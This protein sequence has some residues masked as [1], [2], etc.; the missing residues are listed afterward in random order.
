M[1]YNVRHICMFLLVDCKEA[2]HVECKDRL[3]QFCIP[4]GTTPSKGTQGNIISDFAPSN[5]P[6]VPSIILQCVNQVF[7]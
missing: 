7:V 1:Y 5:P 2:C 6:F 4:K 3:S